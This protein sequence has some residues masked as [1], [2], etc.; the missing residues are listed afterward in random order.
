MAY[1][2]PGNLQVE[3]RID[4]LRRV[5]CRCTQSNA[6]TKDTFGC[7]RRP[8]DVRSPHGVV[9]RGADKEKPR[10]CRAE[11]PPGW[12]GGGGSTSH[13]PQLQVS[14]RPPRDGSSVCVC[15]GPHENAQSSSEQLTDAAHVRAALHSLDAIAPWSGAGAAS[16]I[17]YQRWGVGASGGVPGMSE[18]GTAY[19]SVRAL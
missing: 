16:Q 3:T 12:G 1:Y 18:T 14:T 6:P 5:R 10:R 7:A 13:L 4:R 8:T 2:V 17:D 19:E 9:T 11:K 15:V